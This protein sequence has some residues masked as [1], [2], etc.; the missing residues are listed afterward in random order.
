[1]LTKE[2]L[3]R[4]V[5]HKAHTMQ[6]TVVRV[7]NESIADIRWDYGARWDWQQLDRDFEFVNKEEA[8]T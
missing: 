3:G 1:M 5:R 4:Q 6:G 7:H 8:I 2:D